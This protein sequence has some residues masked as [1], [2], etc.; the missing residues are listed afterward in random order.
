MKSEVGG[1]KPEDKNLE[2]KVGS[3]K[4]EV[5][6]MKSEKSEGRESHTACLGPVFL[7]SDL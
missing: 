7:T 4:S 3:W 5:G 1:M 6:S 2:K